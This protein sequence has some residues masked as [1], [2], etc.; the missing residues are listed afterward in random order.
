LKALDAEWGRLQAA[1][2]SIRGIMAADS[3]DWG[4]ARSALAN[5]KTHAASVE[6]QIQ[7]LNKQIRFAAEQ[8]SQQML[9]DMSA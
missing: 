4:G 2:Q 6:A 8:N 3:V 1:V 9:P 5:L 7:K